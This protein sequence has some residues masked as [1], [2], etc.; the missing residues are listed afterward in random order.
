MMRLAMFTLLGFVT[1]MSPK[2]SAVAGVIGSD[3]ELFNPT[4][5]GVDF[6]TVESAA[7][8]KKGQFNLGVFFDYA[9]GNDPMSFSG[10][11]E[12]DASVRHDLTDTTDF[13][14]VGHFSIGLGIMDGWSAGVSFPTVIYSEKYADHSL[15]L[16]HI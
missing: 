1:F 15:S 3:Y 14:V 12:E 9:L 6:L 10:N 5:D 16:I 11:V 2:Q 4:T 7:T 13:M 8:L